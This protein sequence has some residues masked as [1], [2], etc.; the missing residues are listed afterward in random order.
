MSSSYEPQFYHQVVLFLH[1]RD[2]MDAELKAMELNNTWT[3][4][5]LPKGQHTIG[6][7]W[8]F[9]IKHKSDDSIERYKAR[10]VAKSYS[11]Q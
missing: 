8:I 6:C 11:Q 7:K 2:A 5:P 9:K 3:I 1:W 10:L 4:V